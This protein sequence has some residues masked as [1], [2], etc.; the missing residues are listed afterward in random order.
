MIKN[1][2]IVVYFSSTQSLYFLSLSTTV[3]HRVCATLKHLTW[4]EKPTL[5]S[6]K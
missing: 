2:F 1:Q 6:D 4:M 5:K 3:N